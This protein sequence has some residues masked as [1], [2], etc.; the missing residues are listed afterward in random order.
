MKNL[1]MR[2]KHKNRKFFRTRMFHGLAL[3]LLFGVLAGCMEKEVVVVEVPK[4]DLERLQASRKFVAEAWA[5]P[6]A[7]FNFGE[8][9]TF[10]MRVSSNSYTTIFHVSTS[11][12]VTRLLYN[13][14]MKAGAIVDYPLR[15]SGIRITVKPP[16]GQ[17][18]F[19]I[20]ATR[21][22]L[23]FLAGADILRAQGSGIAR[24]DLNTTQ[25]FE[26]V[27]QFR[28]R[29]NPDELSITTLKISILANPN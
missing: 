20:I 4:C 27:K 13:A 12:K 9:L 5:V 10:Q 1:M 2:G 25:F 8:P 24:L 17:E 11:C 23:E 29:V 16:V 18:A 19:Y 3:V 22:K 26:R 28:D 15:G 14:P 6:D 21:K 7:N